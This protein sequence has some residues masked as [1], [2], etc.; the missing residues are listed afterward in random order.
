LAK[1]GYEIAEGRMPTVEDK[2]GIIVGA[3]V[4]A[5]FYDWRSRRGRGGED[6]PVDMMNTKIFGY[7]N[8]RYDKN[9]NKKRGLRITTTGVLTEAF[10]YTRDYSIFMDIETVKRLIKEDRKKNGQNRYGD[11]VKE[12]EYSMIRVVCDDI[13]QVERVQEAIKEKGYFA[14]SNFD[15]VKNEKKQ[16]EIIQMVL[17]GIG[18]VS[19]FIA[20]I[21][22]TNTM[23]MAIYERT[24]EIGVMKVLGA[25]VP[26]I[27][28]LFLLEALIIGFI[29]GVIGLLVSIGGSTLIDKFASDLNLMS[30]RMSWGMEEE[31]VATKITLIPVWLM[32]ASVIFS[33]LVGGIAGFFP[34]IRATKLS[35]LEA[36]KNE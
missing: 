21:G 10:D 18:I 17:G 22:I 28:R 32:F 33:T 8:G 5:N 23:V 24:R 4:P 31:Q 12:G 16:S 9:G 14:S 2:N 13:F 19:F 25:E 35:A 30:G 36:I 3:H 34:A 20:A 1:L 6:E 11:N 15:W 26:S 29:G 27:L 7:I